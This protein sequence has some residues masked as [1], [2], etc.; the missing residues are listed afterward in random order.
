M[1]E[2]LR[3]RQALE[4]KAERPRDSLAR[5]QCRPQNNMI[6]K[7]QTTR[8]PTTTSPP[9]GSHGF[10]KRKSD[11]LSDAEVISLPVSPRSTRNSCRLGVI[12]V[13]GGGGCC[14]SSSSSR[15]AARQTQTTCGAQEG[16][17]YPG[18]SWRLDS[19]PVLTWSVQ[20]F[21][22][23]A[24]MN[25]NN[26]KSVQINREQRG[27]RPGPQKRNI[28]LLALSGDRRQAQKQDKMPGRVDDRRGMSW[29]GSWTRSPD[30]LRPT[31]DWERYTVPKRFATAWLRLIVM[32][33]NSP[34][35]TRRELAKPVIRAEYRL[36][37]GEWQH[38]GHTRSSR[39]SISRH[40]PKHTASPLRSIHSRAPAPFH[41]ARAF[42]FYLPGPAV[43][44]NRLSQLPASAT[45]CSRT[46][47]DLGREVFGGKPYT[48]RGFTTRTQTYQSRVHISNEN[49]SATFREVTI[50][51]NQSLIRRRRGGGQLLPESSAEARGK[52]LAKFQQAGASPDPR[53]FKAEPNC[54][55]HSRRSRCSTHFVIADTGEDTTSN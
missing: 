15:R 18:G 49:Q 32:I 45:H 24:N 48:R 52:M 30:S 4:H 2:Q 42:T 40:R 6:H 12:S 7:E 33:R 36:M 31:L 22:S 34:S 25:M 28:W 20:V 23:R 50:F 53:W 41:P 10:E 55:Q 54:T 16:P 38:Y 29:A 3:H 21:G 51:T 35:Q 5:Y 46:S 9:E 47:A 11:T 43:H 13:S 44:F 17:N 37:D 27:F 26:E 1:K 39:L 19:I 8:R 14:G